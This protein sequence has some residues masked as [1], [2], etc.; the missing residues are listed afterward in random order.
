MAAFIPFN[1]FLAAV[2]GGNM[3]FASDQLAMTLCA[4]ANAPT[5]S[6]SIIGDL[7]PISFANLSGDLLLTTS[8]AGTVNTDGYRVVVADKQL[9][10]SGGDIGPFQYV[11]VYD[12]TTHDLI[13]Y[14][15]LADNITIP[16]TTAM[17]FD[18]SQVVGLFQIQ[19]A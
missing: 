16:D 19:A 1:G 8:S 18:F 5:A 4:A 6:D 11:V 12:Q 2:A 13:C 15:D 10:A 17:N 3:D 9:L 14:Y 7:T